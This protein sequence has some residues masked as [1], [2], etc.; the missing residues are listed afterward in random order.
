MALWTDYHGLSLYP[1]NDPKYYFLEIDIKLQPLIKPFLELKH[2]DAKYHDQLKTGWL[3]LADKFPQINYFLQAFHFLLDTPPKHEIRNLK[4]AYIHS[5]NDAELMLLLLIS[6]NPVILHDNK[7]ILKESGFEELTKAKTQDEY[8]R[9]KW[10]IETI[11]EVRG[12]EVLVKLELEYI[13]NRDEIQ[14]GDVYAPEC[15]ISPRIYDGKMWIES[16]PRGRGHIVP[17]QFTT[18]PFPIQY[19]DVN[20][21]DHQHIFS[22]YDYLG[23]NLDIKHPSIEYIEYN[24]DPQLRLYKGAEYASLD[25][26]LNIPL[27]GTDIKEFSVVAYNPDSKPTLEEIMANLQENSTLEAL[28]DTALLLG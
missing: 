10:D 3:I 11:I 16:I 14:V 22:G 9:V 25:F 28:N 4:R 24:S 23:I 13:M 6:N 5:N 2:I 21:E 7:A 27:H 19:F 17:K 26:I 20:Y 18:P 8:N 12:D 15:G 1:T